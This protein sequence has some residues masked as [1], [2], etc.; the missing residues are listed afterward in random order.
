MKKFRIN[1]T[2]LKNWSCTKFV[3]GEDEKKAS[4][5]LKDSL[6]KS[7]WDGNP[8]EKK[9]ICIDSIEEQNSKKKKR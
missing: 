1:Y 4:S 5:N 3:N 7:G 9:D 6:V 2:I 8:I